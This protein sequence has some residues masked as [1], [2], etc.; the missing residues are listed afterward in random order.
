[1][2]NPSD[3]EFINR[4]MDAESSGRRYDKNG[5]LLQGP[6]T[7]HG[8]A[9]GEM[10]VIDKT[11]LDPGFGVE[12]AKNK[13]PDERA[14]VGK[15]Y[16]Q[17]MLNRYNNQQH[18][19]MAYNWGP[20]NVDK[21]LAKGQEAPIPEETANY[22]VR[23]TGSPIQTA[24]KAEPTPSFAAAAPAPAAAAGA[25]KA[26]VTPPVR[27]AE[28]APTEDIK[29][30]IAAL[31]PNYQYAMALSYLAGNTDEDDPTIQE[32]RNRR[33]DD[34]AQT[35]FLNEPAAPVALS[36]VELKVRS[37]FQEPVT[38]AR[39]GLIHRAGGS[40]EEGEEVASDSDTMASNT[41]PETG[42]VVTTKYGEQTP[43]YSF[44]GK[45]YPAAQGANLPPS[46]SKQ[47]LEAYVQAMVPDANVREKYPLSDSVRGF[48]SRKDPSTIN[49]SPIL[50]PGSREE[51]MLHEAEHSMD[52]RGG[53]LLGRPNIK[54][55]DNNYRAY[56]LMGSRWAPINMTVKN[57]VD[58][59]D[60][61]EKFF[62]RPL[63]NSYF[64]KE[65]YTNVAKDGDPSALFSEQL[66][67]L[68]ALEQQTGKFLTHDPKMREL[69]FPSNPLYN[70]TSMMAVYDALTGPRQTRMDARD[71]PP[72]TPVPSYLYEEPG[73]M[74]R[75]FRKHTTSPN[76]Y[77]IPIKRADGSPEEGEGS[78]EYSFMGVPRT[79]NEHKLYPKTERMNPVVKAVKS[80][81]DTFNRFIDSGPSVGSVVGDVVGAIPFVGPDLRKSMEDSTVTLPT[82]YTRSPTNP[83]V[84][85]G[86][87]TSKVP[88]TD[89]LNSVKMSDLV[90]GTG[91]S[92]V[93]GSVGKGYA[94]SP[95]DVLDTVGAGAVGYKAAKAGVKTAKK[96]SDM[97][98]ELKAPAQVAADIEP[99]L[100]AATPAAASLSAM[101]T[102]RG[103]TSTP[104][105]SPLDAYAQTLTGPVTAAEFIKQVQNKGFR[106]Y[107]VERA[108]EAMQKLGTGQV[109][110]SQILDS[111]DETYHPESFITKV[112]EPGTVGYTHPEIDNVFNGRYP[113]DPALS[114]TMVNGSGKSPPQGVIS[115]HLPVTDQMREARQVQISLENLRSFKLSL[116]NPSVTSNSV[117]TSAEKAASLIKDIYGEKSEAALDA[118]ESVDLIR[119]KQEQIV[120]YLEQLPEYL[121]LQQEFKYPMAKADAKLFSQKYEQEGKILD[122]QYPNL[123]GT[124]RAQIIT[125]NTVAKLR[126]ETRK[127]LMVFFE[128]HN[129]LNREVKTMFKDAVDADQAIGEGKGFY[130]GL[131]SYAD[132]AFKQADNVI[133]RDLQDFHTATGSEFARLKHQLPDYLVPDLGHGDLY[134]SK[135]PEGEG[136]T[137][138]MLHH[139]H[140]TNPVAF[141]RF[142]DHTVDFNG[143]KMEGMYVTE[144]QSDLYKR[145]KQRGAVGKSAVDD[146]PKIAKIKQEQQDIDSQIKILREEHES[147]AKYGENPNT[148][149][150]EVTGA[151]LRD[152]QNE[153]LNKDILISDI[154]NKKY[155]V[156]PAYAGMENSPQ[157]IQQLA[158]K[159]AVLAGV[160]RGKNFVAFPGV[161]SDQAKLYEKMPRNIDEILRDLGPGFEHQIVRLP[162]PEG[163]DS[164]K[165]Y[166]LM[167]A[168]SVEYPTD[169]NGIPITTQPLTMLSHAIVWNPEAAARILKQGVRFR[170]GG[171]VERQSD[172]NRRY[173]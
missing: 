141:S 14:R 68:S 162:L 55:M 50:S 91:V 140:E 18:A 112:A 44:Q 73:S 90:G 115:L 88:V 46:R 27:K 76:E 43:V 4:I 139:S 165:M 125:K 89:A 20:G 8:T 117:M 131:D 6:K 5:K 33:E 16:A 72:H 45:D 103:A 148:I 143:N 51:T 54:G 13:S 77:G 164:T 79:D 31:G 37:P 17:A 64:R 61:L 12:P 167:K 1:M 124:E 108:K 48:I 21:W 39:G 83:N 81:V 132:L 107:D 11:N 129:V 36:D 101:A 152:L 82:R 66:A 149:S 32:Y 19:A 119:R 56:Y 78:P 74:A 157:V 111:L 100:D 3:Q 126:D 59:K 86:V 71:M 146:A 109:S 128:K 145:L 22:V 15:E 84:A 97:L 53:D 70:N 29:S 105:F 57:L 99:A 63:D 80:G 58:N 34:A 120:P 113:S 169:Q 49:L 160:K 65:T 116:I 23:V 163:V 52:S 136:Y 110:R 67:T 159:N 144:L 47:A 96:A 130:S 151:K 121:K 173:L 75:F 42:R 2:A 9:K 24:K 69:I 30:R 142:T 171:S 158:A 153:L 127:K 102:Q 155:D 114:W 104:F 85:V 150:Y 35:A 62:G 94:P 40:P 122:Q 60:E 92:N 133:N 156:A 172:D 26:P 147:Y 28:A 38:A 10:Q 137:H 135:L 95:L 166:K 98:R 123:S 168:K 170:H 138:M 7:K 161:E 134:S 41:D 118:M 25:P 106:A 154:K 87:E 93:L